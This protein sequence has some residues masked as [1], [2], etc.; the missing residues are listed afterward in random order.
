MKW[1]GVLSLL[2]LTDALILG[3]Q[4]DK[5]LVFGFH[6]ICHADNVVFKATERAIT[7]K[8]IGTQHVMCE[9]THLEK[10]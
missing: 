7:A 4:H 10:D 3:Y 6:T 9:Y 2:K 8:T 1:D 5:A